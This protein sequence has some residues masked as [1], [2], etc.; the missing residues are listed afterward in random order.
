MATTTTTTN[1]QSTPVPDAYR[2]L[3]DVLQLGLIYRD[4]RE[5]GHTDAA[6]GRAFLAVLGRSSGCRKDR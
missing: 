4:L 1:D 6:I 5:Q 2:V 3:V